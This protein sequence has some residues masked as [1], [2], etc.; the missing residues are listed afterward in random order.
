[1][2]CI[3]TAVNVEQTGVKYLQVIDRESANALLTPERVGP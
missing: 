3:A 2:G 1:M